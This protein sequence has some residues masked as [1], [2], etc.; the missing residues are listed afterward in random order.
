MPSTLR[1]IAIHTLPLLTS[2]VA[3]STVGA[4]QLSADVT[5]PIRIVVQPVLA[6]RSVAPARVR[7]ESR[8]EI[9]SAAIVT[10]ESN[11]PYRLTVRL[12]PTAT[13]NDARVFVRSGNGTFQPL[14]RGS[15]IAAVG[16]G[17]PGQHAHEIA[18]RVESPASD[19]CALIYELSAE[20]HD[21]LIRSSATFCAACGL[22]TADA[23]HREPTRNME[24]S[25]G[26]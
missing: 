16:R 25:R 11:L 26:F 1:S 3:V 15:S 7:M 23:H 24:M 8:D 5:V 6:I 9:E 19:G 4:Q 21:T 14:D 17:I 12:A 10:I 2:A 18:C 22:R 13:A 20:Y